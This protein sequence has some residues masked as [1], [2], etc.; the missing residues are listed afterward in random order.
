MTDWYEICAQDC[1]LPAGG[2]PD[3]LVA[4]LAECLGD[5]DPEVRD[6]Y[7]YVVLE[8][9][10]ER[11]VIDG[12]RLIRL[13]DTMAARL[14]DARTEARAFAPLVLDMIVSRGAV[15]REWLDAFARWYPAESDP[16]GYDARL[17]WLHAVAHGADLLGALGRHPGIDPVGVLDIAAARLTVPTDHLYAEREDERLARG[18][19]LTLTHPGLGEDASVGWLDGVAA[20]LRSVPRGPTPAYV[21]NA[22][23]TLR[24]LYVLVDLGVPP[25][26]ERPAL[27]VPHRERVKRGIVEALASDVKYLG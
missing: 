5:P 10:I 13:G 23:R 26:P 17:G 18:I 7:P 9:W 11:G 3:A 2:D 16:R 20:A 15:R 8:T 4:E 6:G 21:S 14:T 27:P 25:C 24:A 22:L 12:D 19:A 1:A